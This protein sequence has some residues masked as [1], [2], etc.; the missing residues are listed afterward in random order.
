MRIMAAKQCVRLPQDTLPA[1]FLLLCNQT[2]QLST[3]HAPLNERA[4]FQHLHDYNGEVMLEVLINLQE[5]STQLID[6]THCC[7]TGSI[8]RSLRLEILVRALKSGWSVG[9]LISGV[10]PK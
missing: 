5:L 3:P 1:C 8:A 2:F 4:P 10:P 9:A 6:S 7:R